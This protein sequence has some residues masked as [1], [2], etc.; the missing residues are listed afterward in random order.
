MPDYVIREI[1]QKN[2][3]EYKEVTG[4]EAA[5]PELDILYMTRIQ[6]ERFADA[7]EYERL[8]DS[9]VLTPEK[10]TC[11]KKDLAILHPL[12]RVNEI[13]VA[14]DKDPRACYFRQARNGKYMREA[15][16]LKLLGLSGDPGEDKR[17]DADVTELDRVCQNPRCIISTEQELPRLFRRKNG[18]CRCLYCEQVLL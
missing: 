9:Y 4:L 3:I 13:S 12:P 10:L 14:V 18:V 2:R 1:L 5:L 17:D 6:K 8:K 11:A 15:L 7:D 16:I